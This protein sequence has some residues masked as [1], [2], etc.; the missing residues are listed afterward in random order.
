MGQAV[1]TSGGGGGGGSEVKVI[2]YQQANTKFS[3][4]RFYLGFKPRNLDV[5]GEVVTYLL[6]YNDCDKFMLKL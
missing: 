2:R 1:P 4:F 6:K 3:Q 5:G